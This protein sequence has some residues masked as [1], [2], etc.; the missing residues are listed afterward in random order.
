MFTQKP[1]SD[2]YSGFMHNDQNLETTHCFSTGEWINT[3]RY[4][5]YNV[6]LLS[7]TKKE[8]VADAINMCE[9]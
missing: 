6:L 7:S 9:S 5:P 2:I 1:V 4:H 8:Q 3:P